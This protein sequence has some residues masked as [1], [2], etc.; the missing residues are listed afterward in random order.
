MKQ[1]NIGFLGCGN[2][3]GGVWRLLREFEA[4]IARREQ[5]AF[6][7]RRVLVR[8][9]RKAR[10]GDIPR[11]IL[12]DRPEDVL[13]DPEIQIVMEFMGGEEP[14]AS[15]IER[16]LLAGKTVV[17]A[18][19]M[20]LSTH[21]AELNATAQKTGTG[22]YFEASVCGAIPVVRALTDSLQ[23]NRVEG[24]MGIINGTTNYILTRMAREGSAFE[25]V[26][27][28]AQRLG[29]AEPDPTADV[30]GYDAAYKLSI[31][32]SLA[33]HT[34]VPVEAVY[35]EGITRVTPLDI[36]CGQEMGLTLKLLAVAKR[37]GDR[38]E[39]RVHPTF[40]PSTHPLASVSDA[41]NAVFLKGH[42]CGEMMFYG[43]GAGDMP[44][45]SA[46]VS[47]L[48]K[49]AGAPR[50]KLPEFF[51]GADGVLVDSDWSS[52]YFIRMRAQDK[53]GVLAKVAGCMAGHDVGIASMVQKGEPD[54][55]GRVQLVFV[56][57]RAHERAVRAALS[58]VERSGETSVRSVIRVEGIE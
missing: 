34:H 1:V 42:A 54:V 18:N 29:L 22:L 15:Y 5:L 26:L 44:T 36:A 32:S 50:H 41:F 35:R 13:C 9:V 11:E 37:S 6:A 33:F 25:D 48:I 46:L 39:A 45:A 38:V 20:A 28:D 21:W 19:K 2:I 55:E 17:T 8:D 3:G 51:G 53:P 14:A 16:A 4:E 57:H 12:T 49:A 30:E 10:G 52:V 43:R 7:V 24:L 31:L 56:T 27:Y 23:A 40:V 47:D 58:E